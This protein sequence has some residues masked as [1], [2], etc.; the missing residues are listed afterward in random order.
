MEGAKLRDIRLKILLLM[1]WVF[2][3]SWLAGCAH[4][5][6][7]P[8]PELSNELEP[9]LVC[10]QLEPLTNVSIEG[11]GLAALPVDTAIGNA[12]L[13]L[14][15][16][17]LRRTSDL[18][19]EA[20]A[21]EAVTVPD[22]TAETSQIHWHSQ[23]RMTFDITPE[24]ELVEGI[25]GL[26][27][28]NPDGQD[29]ALDPALA[30]V[31]PPE[32]ATIEPETIC[33]DQ[34]DVT[35]TLTGSG[36]L[37]ID[38]ALPTVTVVG[39][40]ET[41]EYE[42]TELGECFTL[43]EPASEAQSCSTLS[44]VVPQ[45]DL[46][47]GSYSITVTNPPP[48]NCSSS[49]EIFV[50]VVPP[51][52]L[53]AVVP[54][55]ICTGGGEIELH[56]T[57]F[58]EGAT[59]EAG[60]LEAERVEV[61]PSGESAVATFG[62]GLAEGVYDV[63]ITN[64]EGC[65]DTLEDA[66]EVIQGPVIFWVDPPV[67][68]DG[69]S[70]Q[71]TIFGSGLS[72]TV[73][74]VELVPVDGSEAVELDFVLEETRGRLQAV[75]PAGTPAGAYDVVVHDSICPATLPGGLVVTDTLALTIDQVDPPFGW[76]DQTTSVSIFGTGFVNTPRAYLNPESPTPET[77]A[78]TLN[79]VAFVDESRLTAVVQ[80]GLPAG[81]YDLIVVNSTGEVGLLAGGFTVTDAAPPEIDSISPGEVDNGAVRTINV[82]GTNFAGPEA[83]WVCRAPGG[84]TS[85][86]A[87]SAGLP[88]GPRASRP[89]QWH[90]RHRPPRRRP[91]RDRRAVRAGPRR[92]PT[93]RK[94]G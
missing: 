61:A 18:A 30:V 71:I 32:V 8:T 51:P 55:L 7:G 63:T 74:L 34:F 39:G 89:G 84:A 10:N 62:A 40:S 50:E 16:L 87:G 37:D 11:G 57:G 67:V 15:S 72:D 90:P 73:E 46:P 17:S 80:S 49:E 56:G 82:R 43:P 94:R 29:A 92:A 86:P 6:E 59:V 2:G 45:G 65:S 48:A 31:P 24:M 13:V 23:Q 69:I 25:Y 58:R 28:T 79:T 54:A 12:H 20:A 22:E 53:D 83:T 1:V 91:A 42:P 21:D 44:F 36:F 27:V 81:N 19:G 35:L 4:E 75:V 52:T 70:T 38:G 3:A 64:S 26:T 85:E 14:P 47:P 77:V 78:T 9:H 41:R 93:S 76:T 60:G 33:V 5:L 66:V 88:A 68:Y